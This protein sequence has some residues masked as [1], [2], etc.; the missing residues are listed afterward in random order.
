[1]TFPSTTYNRITTAC[2]SLGAVSVFLADHTDDSFW[3]VIGGCAALIVIS[4]YFAQYFGDPSRF[5]ERFRSEGSSASFLQYVPGPAVAVLAIG[6]PLLVWAVI[7]A[8]G[9][10]RGS[11]LAAARSSFVH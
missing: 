8:C 2:L 5:T 11:G 6:V 7:A 1:M 9:E 4:T 3:L 10:S